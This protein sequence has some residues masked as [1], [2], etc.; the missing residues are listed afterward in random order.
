MHNH[1]L[2]KLATVIL[3]RDIP[4]AFFY[5]PHVLQLPPQLYDDEWHNAVYSVP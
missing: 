4:Y 2:L 1:M 5:D 3:K